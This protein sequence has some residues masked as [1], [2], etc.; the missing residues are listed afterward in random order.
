MSDNIAI[1]Y[2]NVEII[3]DENDNVWRF[4]LR[5]RQRSTESLAKAKE[6]ID[7]PLPVGKKKFER[8]S[9]YLARHDSGFKIVEV[10]SIA[11]GPSW[12]NK[13]E[14]WIT[15]DGNRQKV[16]LDDLYAVT[17]ENEALIA[18]WKQ[19]DLQE[20]E[21]EKAKRVIWYELTHPELKEEQFA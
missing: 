2:N 18:K 19:H 7:K 8:F 16:G 1:V 14:V 15:F 5:G 4:E 11:D 3:Y 6:A 13:T 10:T 21:A 12:R 20:K 9:A 17:P